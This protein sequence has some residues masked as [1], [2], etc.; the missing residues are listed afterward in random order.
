MRQAN[1]ITTMGNQAAISK[2]RNTDIMIR[3]TRI[4][5]V[6]VAYRLHIAR[7]L[8]LFTPVLQIVLVVFVSH[9][10]VRTTRQLIH[11]TFPLTFNAFRVGLG[12]V[13]QSQNGSS[14]SYEVARDWAEAR[15]ADPASRFSF[16]ST[17]AIAQRNDGPTSSATSS[18]LDRLSPSGVSQVL[19]SRRPVT[20]IL[21]PRWTVAPAFS[22]SPCQVIMSKNDV[23]SSHSCVWRFC[24]LRFTAR[25]KFVVAC[26][27]GVNRNSGSRVTLPTSV[28]ELSIKFPFQTLSHRQHYHCSRPSEFRQFRHHR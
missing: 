12:V 6:P 16:F 13:A 4:K 15:G 27:D 1:P 24:H 8:R 25:P 17:A 9:L 11:G 28:M 14:S 22:A 20:I 19:C 10:I 18:I 21:M 3:P 23:D 2:S 26:P 5:D 7:G